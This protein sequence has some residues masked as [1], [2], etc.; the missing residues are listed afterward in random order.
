IHGPNDTMGMGRFYTLS[1]LGVILIA[2]ADPSNAESNE[3]GENGN[4]MLS[5][6]YPDGPLVPLVPGERRIQGLVL[7]ELFSVMVGWR[8][9]VS[10]IQIRIQ[11]LENF[12]VTAGGVTKNLG[13]PSD[14]RLYLNAS[15]QPIPGGSDRGSTAM[16]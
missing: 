10:D 4:Q 16:W 5:E 6:P 13:F 2:N 3:T 9:M 11:G 12:S 1:E 7:H 14:G 15:L 8:F